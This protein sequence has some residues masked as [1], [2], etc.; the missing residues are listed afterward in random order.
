[1]V[2]KSTN[3]TTETSDVSTMESLDVIPPKPKASISQLFSFCTPKKQPMEDDHDDDGSAETD[4][5]T[6]RSLT[7]VS[8]DVDGGAEKDIV[9]VIEKQE[10][11]AEAK[12][13]DAGLLLQIGIA[14]ALL[15]IDKL[16]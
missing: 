7:F 12:L 10:E 14:S 5:I 6:G 1:M 3:I 2:I 16:V 13:F 4:E 11:A 9:E 15:A 8:E